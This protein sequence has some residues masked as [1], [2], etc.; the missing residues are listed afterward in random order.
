MPLPFGFANTSVA[1]CRQ[2]RRVAVRVWPHASRRRY[3]HA[4][5]FQVLLVCN[6]IEIKHYAPRSSQFNP[7]VP[8]LATCSW[9]I[10]T[11]TRA[12][13]CFASTA[14][15]NVV[16]FF[17]KMDDGLRREPARLFF[18]DHGRFCGSFRTCF[19]DL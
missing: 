14:D 15:E 9:V 2:Y 13:M 16:A 1:I 6:L 3:A 12:D 19:R 18:G 7:S 5:N 10:F 17:N 4:G 8:N 11:A